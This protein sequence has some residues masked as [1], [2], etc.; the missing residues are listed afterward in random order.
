MKSVVCQ[1]GLV[2]AMLPC[3]CCYIPV[4]AHADEDLKLLIPETKIHGPDAWKKGERFF[5][6]KAGILTVTIF[7]FVIGDLRAQVVDVMKANI[8]REPLQ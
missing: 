6:L 7:Q 5:R 2:V 4:F 8:S 3:S 1:G